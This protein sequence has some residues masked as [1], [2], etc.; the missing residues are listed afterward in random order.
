[1]TWMTILK[2]YGQGPRT[3]DNKIRRRGGPPLVTL[4]GESKTV[5]QWQKDEDLNIHG[6]SY[7]ILK[8][9]AD[10]GV[11]DIDKFFAP[12]QPARTAKQED[13]T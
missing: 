8:K 2:A 7:R 5:E 3:P 4:G 1:M 13:K 10:R 11:R 12:L 6:L 9:R